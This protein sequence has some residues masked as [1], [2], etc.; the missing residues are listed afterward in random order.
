MKIGVPCLSLKSSRAAASGKRA[1]YARGVA[2][3]ALEERWGSDE[4][5]DESRS[6]LNDYVV[7]PGWE[8]LGFESGQ[9][10]S[11]WW[12]AEADKQVRT[13]RVKVPLRDD[14]GEKVR[15]GDGNVVY[16]T[17]D[18]GNVVYE[19]RE[20]KLREDAGIGFAVIAKADSEWVNSL[21][22]GERE[23]FTSDLIDVTVGVLQ[24]AGLVVQVVAVHRDEQAEHPHILGYDPEYKMA[25]KLKLPLFGKFNAEIPRR[26][27]ERGWG[28]VED[29]V[30]YD[31]EKVEAEI[32][33]LTAGMDGEQAAAKRQEY[34]DDLIVKK[35]AKKKAGRSAKKYKADRDEERA[36]KAKSETAKAERVLDEVVELH[37]KF[38]GSDTFEL[39]G[40]TVMGL[41]GALNMRD[42]AAAAA[43]AARAAADAAERDAE[44]IVAEA[45][46]NV[47]WA[48]DEAAGIAEFAV[49][50]AEASAR[51]MVDAAKSDADAIRTAAEVDVN[52][53]RKQAKRE[54]D[55]TKV[56]VAEGERRLEKRR[57]SL[58]AEFEE[59]ARSLDAYADRL[60][61]V[62]RDDFFNYVADVTSSEE[63]MRAMF[64]AKSD[65]GKSVEDDIAAE[66]PDARKRGSLRMKLMNMAARLIAVVAQRWQRDRWHAIDNAK[67][68]S[69]KAL[70]AR[71]DSIVE[72]YDDDM[73]PQL[74]VEGLE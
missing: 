9:A 19:E 38:I 34:M 71:I 31:K 65:D 24:E 62:E 52:R 53:I 7:M 12:E 60:A 5:I 69:R 30:A 21:P 32:A 1:G 48:A 42:D 50:D 6:H 10:L 28:D 27:R 35:K 44:A 18:D 17:D 63:N 58:E 74:D 2:C 59:R 61:D 73:S 43:I 37:A 8:G 54:V 46:C 33:E 55:A 70:R 45:M 56:K 22:D 11:D 66:E 4:D 3:E 41:S 57:Q 25:S 40:E 23:R 14:A 13:V 26:M 49:H 15:D 67:Q 72:R 16:A 36:A 68:E 51:E 20:R 47:R 39:N 64:S 29:C